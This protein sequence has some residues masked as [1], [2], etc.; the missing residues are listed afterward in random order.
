MQLKSAVLLP[1]LCLVAYFSVTKSSD[2]FTSME[3]LKGLSRLETFLSQLLDQYVKSHRF[4][5][6]VVQDFSE[7]MKNITRERLAVGIDGYINHPSNVF[8]L[9]R[10]FLKHWSELA[11]Y[12]EQGPENGK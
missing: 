7:N 12:L 3:Q 2:I 10:R 6:K 1:I 8:L 5:P 11:R 9:V 4:A